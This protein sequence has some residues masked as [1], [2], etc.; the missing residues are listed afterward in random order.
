MLCRLA[1]SITRRDIWAGSSPGARPRKFCRSTQLLFES[2]MMVE[3]LGMWY[4]QTISTSIHSY[5]LCRFPASLSRMATNPI[6]RLCKISYDASVRLRHCEG[7]HALLHSR[8]ARLSHIILVLIDF[9]LSERL[10]R[11]AATT[12]HQQW[13]PQLF[14]S[15]ELADKLGKNYR[16]R[17]VLSVYIRRF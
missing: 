9:R 3:S 13:T 16:K 12:N 4:F 6:L 17:T 2:V 8:W 14:I 15:P 5:L 11:N 1:A 7:A 10:C